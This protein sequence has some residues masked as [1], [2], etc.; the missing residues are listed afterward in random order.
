MCAVVKA[1]VGSTEYK[2]S[3]TSA[4]LYASISEV[5]FKTVARIHQKKCIFHC[6]VSQ[7]LI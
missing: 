3:V 6:A 7:Y 5:D 4:P 2:K 1:K